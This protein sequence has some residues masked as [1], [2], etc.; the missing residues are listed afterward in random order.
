M[1]TSIA[2]TRGINFGT[3][4]LRQVLAF[5]CGGLVVWKHRGNIKRLVTGTESKFSLH[6]KKS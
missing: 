4:L 2:A 5:L 3:V 1:I 6:R